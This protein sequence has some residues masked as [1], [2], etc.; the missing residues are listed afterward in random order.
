[1]KD[2]DALRSASD[3]VSEQLEYSATKLCDDLYKSYFKTEQLNDEHQL[4]YTTNNSDENSDEKSQMLIKDEDGKNDDETIVKM[5]EYSEHTTAALSDRLLS[6]NSL[7]VN[8][9]DERLL[10]EHAKAKQEVNEKKK[11]KENLLNHLGQSHSTSKF[12]HE[13]HH[14]HLYGNRTMDLVFRNIYVSIPASAPKVTN[15][16]LITNSWFKQLCSKFI[17]AND[18]LRF[19]S[20]K[21]VEQKEQHKTAAAAAVEHHRDIL[22]NVSGYSRPGQMLAVMGPSG[23]GKTTLLNTLSG[24]LKA[25]KGSI[26]VNNEELNKQVKRRI[27]Y[28]MQNDVFFAGLT[29]KQTLVVS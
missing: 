24:R 8:L 9:P 5:D 17:Y 13:H 2:E 6:E 14:H 21:L 10:N 16:N 25:R 20:S 23:C 26:T 22:S 19:K 4:D 28:V 27:G 15:Q 29:L 18:A 1:M 3:D 11:C 7:S 12:S